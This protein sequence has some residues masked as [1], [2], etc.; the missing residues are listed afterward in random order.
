MAA[1]ASQLDPSPHGPPV[2]PATLVDRWQRADEVLL[3]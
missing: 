3:A 2:V 1:F